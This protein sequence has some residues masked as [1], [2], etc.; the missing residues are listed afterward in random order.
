MTNLSHE[1]TTAK[2][3]AR[4][5]LR[6]AK[7]HLKHATA[8]VNKNFCNFPLARDPRVKVKWN[9]G[10]KFWWVRLPSDEDITLYFPLSTPEEEC[11]GPN[12]FDM[13]VLWRL[14]TTALMNKTNK[15]VFSSHSKL[16]DLLHLTADGN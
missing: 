6:V 10:R 7:K 14:S 8:L 15:A 11:K 9:D 12:A 16:L 1:R 13:N 5:Q 4:E 3:K 2:G